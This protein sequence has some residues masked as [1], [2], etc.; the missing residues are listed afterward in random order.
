MSIQTAIQNAQTKVANVYTAIQ[1]KG[2]I[3]PI[4]KNLANLPD[5]IATIPSNQRKYG[6]TVED[7]LGDVDENG[8]LQYPGDVTNLTFNGVVCIPS[9][10]MLAHKFYNN[11]MLTYVD[12]PDLVSIHNTSALEAAFYG[13]TALST[14]KMNCLVEIF[15]SNAL[16]DTFYDCKSITDIYFPM[17]QSSR[18]DSWTTTTFKGANYLE[19]VHF[20][21]DMASEV[22]TWNGASSVWGAPFGEIVYDI[23]GKITVDNKTYIRSEQDSTINED[24][25]YTGWI[26]A[27]ITDE[28]NNVYVRENAKD[29]YNSTQKCIVYGWYDA[30]NDVHAYTLERTPTTTSKLYTDPAQVIAMSLRDVDIEIAYT[31]ASKEPVEVGDDVYDEDFTVIGSVNTIA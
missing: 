20:R 30:T 24:I 21:M 10:Y 6:A 9:V 29:K 11:K 22:P 13:N 25:Q 12:F 27:T 15:G 28:N 26:S 5:T 14:F 1:A 17:L 19:K 18:F 4:T 8:L 23:V 7:L 16:K 31:L 2:G 3:L